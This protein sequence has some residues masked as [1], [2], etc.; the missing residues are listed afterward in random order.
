MQREDTPIEQGSVWQ[1]KQDRKR[2]EVVWVRHLP[3]GEHIQFRNAGATNLK[4]TNWLGADS[5][6]ARYEPDNTPPRTLA[7]DLRDKLGLPPEAN[8]AVT[9]DF[10]YRGPLRGHEA[11]AFVK[12]AE[13]PA[14]RWLEVPANG[15]YWALTVMG[16]IDGLYVEM[17]CPG[18][19]KRVEGALLEGR[20]KA[21]GTLDEE[22]QT[23]FPYAYRV[24]A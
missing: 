10:G 13:K 24:P 6:L 14:W 11:V 5:F 2:V 20:L 1:R 22:S 9:V 17:S 7:D 15:D 4:N 12:R 18:G 8:V 23:P 21:A 3:D 19:W 16:Y